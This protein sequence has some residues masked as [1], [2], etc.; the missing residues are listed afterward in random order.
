MPDEASL[1]QMPKA[2]LR[3]FDVF[4]EFHRLQ[5]ERMGTTFYR[6]VFS[7][8]IEEAIAQGKGYMEIRDA[9]RRPWNERRKQRP[10]AA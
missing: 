6:T 4:A 2:Q 8:A 1:Q 9:I 7:P 3:R 10:Q 5:N